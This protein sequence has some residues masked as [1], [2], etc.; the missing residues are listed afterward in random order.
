MR[1]VVGISCPYGR[2]SILQFSFMDK[3]VGKRDFFSV[4]KEV[5]EDGESMLCLYTCIS[6]P[7]AGETSQQVCALKVLAIF[8]RKRHDSLICIYEE[9]NSVR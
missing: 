6:H 9:Y 7:I 5:S 2:S 3:T 4:M 1:A 8:T